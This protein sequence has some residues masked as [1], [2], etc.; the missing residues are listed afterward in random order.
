[1]GHA[2]RRNRQGPNFPLIN[3]LIFCTAVVVVLFGARACLKS[4]PSGAV[5][6]NDY[7]EWEPPYV[8][9]GWDDTVPYWIMESQRYIAYHM[10]GVPIYRYRKVRVQRYKK[11]RKW[12]RHQRGTSS[13]RI[14]LSRYR[15]SDARNRAKWFRVTK[16][17]RRSRY[18]SNTR[19]SR[20]RSSR[21]GPRYRSRSTMRRFGFRRYT[22]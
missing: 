12:Q 8:E 11:V 5:S 22:K 6:Q 21:S 7:D 9:V 13:Y 19:G 17:P 4:M 16:P 20:Y 14:A 1:M 10:K 15:S 3:F 18:R 2:H